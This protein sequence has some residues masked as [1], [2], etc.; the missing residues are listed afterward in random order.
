MDPIVSL[1]PAVFE[2]LEQHDRFLHRDLP[3]ARTGLL[4]SELHLLERELAERLYRRAPARVLCAAPGGDLVLD[5]EWLWDRR[6]RIRRELARR[7]SRS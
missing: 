6:G 7:R 1:L 3:T 4:W 5:Q 2:S